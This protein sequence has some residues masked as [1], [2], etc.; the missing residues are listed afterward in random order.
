MNG[1]GEVPE[2]SQVGTST[3]H[4]SNG[5]LTRGTK[6]TS[7]HSW[8]EIRVLLGIEWLRKEYSELLKESL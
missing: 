3:S 5:G 1:S 4:V 7:D 2:L 8:D 6:W